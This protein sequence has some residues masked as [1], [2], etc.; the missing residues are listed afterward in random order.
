[1]YTNVS[2]NVRALVFAFA[3]FRYFDI[4]S[5]RSYVRFVLFKKI[6]LSLLVFL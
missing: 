5:R 2:E 1:M 4:Y 6:L 3:R